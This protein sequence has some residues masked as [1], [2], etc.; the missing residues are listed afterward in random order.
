MIK[1]QYAHIKVSQLAVNK[2]PS[3]TMPFQH[4]R[5][6]ITAVRSYSTSRRLATRANLGGPLE[7]VN[8]KLDSGN[9]SAFA[10]PG[11]CTGLRRCT[12]GSP[13]KMWP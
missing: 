10:P 3:C 4:T 8:S 1:Q 11:A 13:W 12:D 2:L 6:Q 5:H 9:A 7:T